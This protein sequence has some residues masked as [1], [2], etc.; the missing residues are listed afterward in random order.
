M[1]NI[2]CARLGNMACLHELLRLPGR[3]GSRAH[4]LSPAP[5]VEMDARLTAARRSPLRSP[6]GRFRR[7]RSLRPISDAPVARGLSRAEPARRLPRR[8]PLMAIQSVEHWE[9]KAR[10]AQEMAGVALHQQTRT[11]ILEL[12]ELYRQLAYQTR[13]MIAATIE[14]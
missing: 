1:R 10:L 8:E 7:W 11:Q 13:R 12:V 6:M 4:H 5:A 14:K 3:G 9:Q 2:A